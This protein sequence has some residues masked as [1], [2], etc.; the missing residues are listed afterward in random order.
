MVHSCSRGPRPLARGLHR[1]RLPTRS[2]RSTVSPTSRCCW[3]SLRPVRREPAVVDL[4]GDP[5]T[6]VTLRVHRSDVPRHAMA[7]FDDEYVRTRGW[8]VGRGPPRSCA[9][10]AASTGN[11]HDPHTSSRA[12]GRVVTVRIGIV[13]NQPPTTTRR[14]STRWSANKAARKAS[15]AGPRGS[16]SSRRTSTHDH[17]RAHRPG[18]SRIELGATVVPLPSRHPIALGRRRST[19]QAACGTLPPSHWGRSHTTGSS[20]PCSVFPYEGTSQLVA[21]YLDVF[22][23]DVRRTNQVDVENDQLHIHNQ[24]D[25]TDLFPVLVSRRPGSG[26]VA[27]GWSA[28][29]AR[30]LDGRRASHRRAH[31]ADVREGRPT[32]AD[33]RR[34]SSRGSRSC[35]CTSSN[36]TQRGRAPNEGLA[37]AQL[38]AELSAVSSNRGRSGTTSPT[39]RWSTRS[40]TSNGIRSSLDAG[41]TDFSAQILPLGSDEEEIV[42]S[43]ASPRGGLA[44]LA[45]DHV[46]VANPRGATLLW[47]SIPR[48]SPRHQA[49]ALR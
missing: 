43:F 7:W 15:S 11:T 9:A 23:R 5:A 24:L 3:S 17:G 10:T 46:S 28:P 36:D 19:V 1:G 47:A 34:A 42:A 37:T 20:T 48:D 38:L 49:V 18:T 31:R 26:D 21:D 14:R 27:A 16:R 41:A 39:C 33:L 30:A 2:V 29:T 25:V 45:A 44:S 6:D 13:V 40:R 35:V 4:A 8:R 22:D 12:R 32:Q